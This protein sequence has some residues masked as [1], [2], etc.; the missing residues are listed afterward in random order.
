[1]R[2][3]TSLTLARGTPKEI[4][5]VVAR[6]CIYLGEVLV[7]SRHEAAG[8]FGGPSHKLIECSLGPSDESVAT[9]LTLVR[10]ME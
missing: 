10:R 3:N 7:G 1:M 4:K 8:R 5:G 9:N 2:R 6:R